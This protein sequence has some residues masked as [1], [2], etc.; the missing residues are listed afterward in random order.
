MNILYCSIRIRMQRGKMEGL[1]WTTVRQKIKLEE[2]L[3][4]VFFA[5]SPRICNNPLEILCGGERVSNKLQIA[6]TS[7]K[8]ML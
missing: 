6:I 1:Q 4:L 8:I 3:L 2:P 7:T 5:S